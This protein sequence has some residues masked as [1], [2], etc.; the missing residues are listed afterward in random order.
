MKILLV[1][2]P[3]IT[4]NNKFLNIEKE[5]LKD[6][7]RKTINYLFGYN[8]PKSIENIFNLKKSKTTTGFRY[9]VRAGSRWPWTSDRPHGD[10][11]YPFMLGYSSSLLKENGF[12]VDIEDLVEGAGEV[13]VTI[14]LFFGNILQGNVGFVVIRNIL[15]H[16]GHQC[17][18]TVGGDQYGAV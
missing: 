5:I 12:E 8:I 3:F 11:P 16:I 13:V 10:A 6:K 18:G 4:F 14:P 15:H 9:G 2:A 17:V 1:N 7:I